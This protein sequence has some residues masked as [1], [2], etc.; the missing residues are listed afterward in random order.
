MGPWAQRLSICL[1]LVGAGCLAG[2]AHIRSSAA[3]S[4]MADVSIAT[5]RHDDVELVRQAIPTYLLLLE[6]LMVGDPDN[7]DLL[8]AASEGYTAYGALVE[9]DDPLRARRLYGRARSFGLACLTA[10]RPAVKG[11]LHAPFADFCAIDRQ[12]RHR[13]LPY[14]F[15]AASSWGAWIGAHTDSIA[16]LADL[17]RVI[18]LM[19]WVL[20]Q[21][22]TFQGGSPHVFLGVYHAALPPAFG[23]DPERSRQHFERALE[24]SGRKDLMVLVRMARSYACQ[25]LDRELYLSLLEEALSRSIDAAPGLTLQNAVAQRMARILLEEVDVHF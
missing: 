18:H 12:L 4:V 9:I 15:W 7:P 8:R 16:A 23:G 14:V 24:L 19:E 6:G 21:E 17:P 11:L 5:V 2:C 22:E 13:D 20:A 3:S 10:R 25:V 1:F